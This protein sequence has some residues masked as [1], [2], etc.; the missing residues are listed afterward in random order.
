MKNT[1]PTPE[2]NHPIFN[3]KG[4]RLEQQ[5]DTT[6]AT[7]I[8]HW[9]PTCGGA[10]IGDES[11]PLGFLRYDTKEEARTLGYKRIDEIRQSLLS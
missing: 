5:V 4:V 6:S 10:A 3:R 1:K 8:D 9:V 2:H 11:T 7:I